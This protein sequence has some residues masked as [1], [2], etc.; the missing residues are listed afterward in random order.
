MPLTMGLA[1]K[2]A[3]I[4]H[5]CLIQKGRTHVLRLV[6]REGNPLDWGRTVMVSPDRFHFLAEE[7]GLL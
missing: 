3:Y 4:I 7:Y 5:R 2:L 1:D 6:D